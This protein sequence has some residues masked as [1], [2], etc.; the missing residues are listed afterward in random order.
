MSGPVSF[1]TSNLLTLSEVALKPKDDDG[2]VVSFLK[3][4]TVIAV[5]TLDQLVRL[6]ETVVSILF[7]KAKEIYNS[8]KFQNGKRVAIDYATQAKDFVVDQATRF[9]Q[10]IS[11]LQRP[12]GLQ[13]S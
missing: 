6:I 5:S 12:T 2:K 11:Q 8:E 10:T 13:S 4:G 1:F 9:Y 3:A 7:Y